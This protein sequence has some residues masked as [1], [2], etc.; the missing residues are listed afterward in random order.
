MAI[1]PAAPAFP[2][3]ACPPEPWRRRIDLARSYFLLFRATETPRVDWLAVDLRPVTGWDFR[4]ASTADF[5]AAHSSPAAVAAAICPENLYFST[6]F[7][8]APVDSVVAAVVVGFDLCRQNCFAIVTADSVAVDPGSDR[9]RFVA[10]LF[11]V[12]VVAEVAV[13]VFLSDAVLSAQSSF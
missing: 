12:A 8:T 9:R 5:F 2:A 4:P 3:I 11:S 6:G 7:A 10:D 1:L 13:S